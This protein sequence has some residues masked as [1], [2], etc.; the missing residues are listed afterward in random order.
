M[1]VCW[2]SLPPEQF[3]QYFNHYSHGSYTIESN[4]APILHLSGKESGKKYSISREQDCLFLNTSDAALLSHISS[5]VS[6]NYSV[7]PNCAIF[8]SLFW[9][10]SAYIVSHHDEERS[11]FPQRK[12]LNKSIFYDLFQDFTGNTDNNGIVYNWL[13]APTRVHF[14]R[15]RA[16]S[17][18]GNHICVRLEFFGA[19]DSQ[20]ISSVMH[21]CFPCFT[22]ANDIL[23]GF[24][25]A[26]DFR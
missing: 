9:P 4:S 21:C 15:F 8:R 14:V 10:E 13:T 17:I 22:Y 12:E 24:L 7:S 3:Q 1:I 23:P 19:R 16:T 6:Q 2:N 11:Y 26:L 5:P 18:S 25:K 20:G